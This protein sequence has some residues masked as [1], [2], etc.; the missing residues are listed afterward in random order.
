V[1]NAS[2]VPPR[3]R[4]RRP[5]QGDPVVDRAFALLAAFDA[6]HRSLTLGELSRR[7]GIPTSS[8]LRLAGRLQAWGALERGSDGRGSD[9]RA[10][11]RRESEMRESEMRQIAGLI[12]TAIRADPQTSGG[13]TRLADVRDE[14]TTLVRRFP[15]YGRQEVHS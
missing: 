3:V 7:S 9:G 6:G 15:A 13:A 10:P 11:D 12:A 2:P 5:P 14:V 4:G 1:T 8:T